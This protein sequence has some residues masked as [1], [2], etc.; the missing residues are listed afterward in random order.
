MKRFST[1]ICIAA[2]SMV[3]YSCGAG[4]HLRQG[5]RFYNMLA[6]NNATTEYEK[7]LSKKPIPEAKIKLAESY[8][9]MN[10]M[11]KAETVY[12]CRSDHRCEA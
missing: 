5:N 7:A 11:E 3:L 8:R 6:Y 10:N 1:F 12:V 9:N 4:Y 2:V